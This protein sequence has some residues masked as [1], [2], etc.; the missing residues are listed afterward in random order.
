MRVL[1]SILSLASIFFFFYFS[2]T[3][4]FSESHTHYYRRIDACTHA[5][6]ITSHTPEWMDIIS[7]V[8]SC[9]TLDSR[10]CAVAPLGDQSLTINEKRIRTTT[11][12]HDQFITFDQINFFF[13]YMN[14]SFFSLNRINYRTLWMAFWKV[15]IANYTCIRYHATW[16]NITNSRKK[17]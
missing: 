8:L 3:T 6:T 14:L 7:T 4:I 5:P 17:T 10:T 1:L 13:L 2:S 16:T 9:I 15:A 11:N 12:S